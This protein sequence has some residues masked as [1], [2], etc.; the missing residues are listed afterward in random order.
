MPRTTALVSLL[1]GLAAVGSA[2]ASEG[3]A[4]LGHEADDFRAEVHGG[5]HNALDP[6]L[7]LDDQVTRTTCLPSD[8]F[9][10]T[11]NNKFTLGGRDFVFAGWNQWEVLEAASDAP[12]PFRHLPLPG[13]EHVVRLMNE[14]VENGLKVGASENP[15]YF[16]PAATRRL[17][18]LA[19]TFPD[20]SPPRSPQ[21]ACGRTPS[22]PATRSSPP[23][24]YGT[25]TSSAA[26]TSS[27]PRRESADSRS[28]GASFVGGSPRPPARDSK[29]EHTHALLRGLS[30]PRRQSASTLPSLR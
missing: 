21:F 16:F 4:L 20:P 25:R 9:V 27:S 10:R 12:P 23:P 19:L 30:S 7:A 29:R 3:R 24:E 28:Y 17:R 6:N 5:M 22:P 15:K 26:W 8:D 1:V 13:R 14:A 2:V 18:A 11:K